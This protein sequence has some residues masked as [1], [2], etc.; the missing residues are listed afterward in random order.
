MQ[1]KVDALYKT[2]KINTIQFQT[3]CLYV[4]NPLGK[5]YLKNMCESVLMEE[6]IDPRNS[7]FAWHDG[8]R[9][10][11]RDVKLIIANINNI[12][13]GKDNV[14]DSFHYGQEG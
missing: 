1:N 5:E 11:W 2:G 13:E 7:M 3:Y 8:R 6:P 12:L 10:H 14:R 4:L 9:A